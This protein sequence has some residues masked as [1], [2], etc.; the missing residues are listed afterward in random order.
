MVFL[1]GFLLTSSCKLLVISGNENISMVNDRQAIRIMFYNTENLFDTINNPLTND[2]EFLP[3]GANNWNSWRYYDKLQKIAKV[4]IAVGEWTPPDLIGLC[5]IENREVLNDLIQLT[6]LKSSGYRI[7]H[8]DSPDRRGIDVALLYKKDTFK[9]LYY[10][11][12][13]VTYPDDSSFKTRDILYVKGIIYEI[14]TLNIFINH[15][16]SRRGGAEES[17]KNR[18]LAASLLKNK[19]DSIFGR[20]DHAFIVITGDFNDEPSDISISQILGANSDSN[21][22]AG[23]QL[24]NLFGYLEKEGKGTYKYRYEWDQIDQIIVSRTFFESTSGLRILK[25][26][27]KI[28]MAEWIMEDDNKYQGKKTWRTFNGK[29]YNNGYSD[30]LPVFTDIF[31]NRKN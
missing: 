4:I 28:F 30:H 26:G 16:P 15:W 3:E 8:K 10:E 14:D 27:G 7:I 29:F 18:I 11:F 21:E 31:I 20:S 24:Y 22:I 13:E 17:E 9:P 6:A 12:I 1:L 25:D 19:V 23:H 5:E 2:E